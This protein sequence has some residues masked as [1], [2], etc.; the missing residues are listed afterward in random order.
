MQSYRCNSVLIRR[1]H[2]NFYDDICSVGVRMQ[3]PQAHC[4]RNGSEHPYACGP[5]KQV[6]KTFTAWCT[7]AH[8][9]HG[10]TD[11]L[12]N[13]LQDGV[14]K[15]CLSDYH[16]TRRL[17]AHLHYDRRCAINHVALSERQ[18]QK[19]GRN[20]RQ[21]DKDRDLPLPVVRPRSTTH[22][23]ADE[24]EDFAK[25]DEA[26]NDHSFR[27]SISE[28]VQQ[29]RAAR[30][31]AHEVQDRF[32]CLLRSTVI[33]IADAWDALVQSGLQEVTVRWSLPWLFSDCLEEVTWPIAAYS[34]LNTMEAKA[35]IINQPPGWRAHRVTPQVDPGHVTKELFVIHFYSGVRRVGDIQWWAEQITPPHG[36]FLTTISV[37][38]IFHRDKGDLT[39]AECQRKWLHFLRT[40]C[41]CAIYLGPPCSTWSISRWRHL[42]EN[43]NGPRPVRSV[44]E[45]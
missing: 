11:P 35:D 14:C 29:C 13:F 40:A 30:S 41:V 18:A 2:S 34:N 4:D 8:K 16:T 23:I 6:F 39:S 25:V 44:S 10:R 45:P 33:N 26:L 43:D 28:L 20:A 22:L 32:R 42:T 3:Q 7:H 21:E 27:Q 37:D 1:W 15:C 5:C 24:D 17:L 31:T 36:H 12:R 38:I 9:K 19:P